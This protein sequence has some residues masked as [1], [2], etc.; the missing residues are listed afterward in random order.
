MNDKKIPIQLDED[1][2]EVT[3]PSP[4]PSQPVPEAALGYMAEED[5]DEETGEQEPDSTIFTFTPAAEPQPVPESGFLNVTIHRGIDLEKKDITGKSDPY[6][7][8]QYNDQKMKSRVFKNNL[9]PEFNFQDQFAY[10]VGDSIFLK[11]DL[12]DDDVG[13]DEFLGSVEVDVS[14][15]VDGRDII[16]HYRDLEGV[17]R[18]KICYS[19]EFT[20]NEVR[21]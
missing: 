13:K 4:P 21:Y 19:V 1:C 17:K 12:Y 18:G 10:R 20:H 9:N 2:V 8:L 6:I 15:V 3:D 16:N 5:D 14:G 11:V 7:I